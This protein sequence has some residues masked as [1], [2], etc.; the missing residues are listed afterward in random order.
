MTGLL[1]DTHV[2]LWFLSGSRKL[3]DTLKAHIDRRSD[4]C[5]LSPISIWE[6]GLL[7]QRGRIRIKGDFTA[8]LREA[9][10]QLPWREASINSEVALTS[11]NIELPHRDP[12]DHFLA[13]TALVYDLE[14]ATLDS[15]LASA[16]WLPTVSG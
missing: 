11:L 14:L 15:T 13:A 8:W 9:R 1:L 7:H 12:A 3:P 2:W 6:V 10:S 4:S 5:W 16:E